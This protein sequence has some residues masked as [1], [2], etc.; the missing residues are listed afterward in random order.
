[1]LPCPS[2]TDVAGAVDEARRL[3]DGLDPRLRYHDAR[4]TFGEVLPAARLLAAAE[5]LS[6]RDAALVEVAAAWHDLGLLE[7]RAGHEWAG[8]RMV[9]ERLPR[10]GFAPEDV[11]AVAGMI[12]ATRLP[13][14]PT[15]RAERVIADADLA[16]LAAPDFL[17]RNEDLRIET[18]LL[19]GWRPKLAWWLSQRRFLSAHVDHTVAARERYAA[20]R[21]RNADALAQR[22]RDFLASPDA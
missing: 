8:V 12:L 14:R 2:R 19:D 22:A 15:T 10:L 16:V 5:G 3:A 9:R 7:T 11:E 20:A 1:M 6:A 4:H 18:S 17:A 21:R 13:Q